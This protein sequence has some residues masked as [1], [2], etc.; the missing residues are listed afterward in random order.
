VPVA[1]GRR[2]SGQCPPLGQV[3]ECRHQNS[4]GSRSKRG[5]PPHRQ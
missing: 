1:D 3:G 2:V 4:R 5:S